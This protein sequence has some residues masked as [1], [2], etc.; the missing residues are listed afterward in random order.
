MRLN[1]NIEHRKAVGSG[2]DVSG[3]FSSEADLALDFHTAD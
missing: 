1:F 3:F 2:R